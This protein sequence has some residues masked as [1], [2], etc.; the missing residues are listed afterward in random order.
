[1]HRS[2]FLRNTETKVQLT[3]EK[4][5]VQYTCMRFIDA[6]RKHDQGILGFHRLCYKYKE[7]NTNLY[8]TIIN[9]KPNTL[10]FKMIA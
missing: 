2:V 9:T 8:L 3:E 6:G 7:N 1:M 4:S 10:K 5:D